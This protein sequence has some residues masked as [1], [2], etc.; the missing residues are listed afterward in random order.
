MPSDSGTA[1]TPRHDTAS[2]RFTLSV[3]GALAVLDY[4]VIDG[5]TVE[6]HHTLVPREIRGRGVASRLVTYALRDALDNRLRVIPTCP[7]VAAF[8]RRHPEYAAVLG[9]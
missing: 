2:H 4:R 6:Y 7:F 1:E 9:R 3:D 8:V 5:T